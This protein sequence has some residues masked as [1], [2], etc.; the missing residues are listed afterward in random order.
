MLSAQANILALLAQVEDPALTAQSWFA[1]Q[2]V[3]G[4]SIVLIALVLIFLVIL[5]SRSWKTTFGIQQAHYL[6]LGLL[7]AIIAMT[8]FAL[9]MV[10]LDAGNREH[11][12]TIVGIVA[13][14]GIALASTP[15]LSNAMAGL[16]LITGGSFRPGDYI[17]IGENFGRVTKRRL[18][19]LTMQTIDRDLL[20][21]PNLYVVSNPHK[22]IR[23]SG[24]IISCVVSLGYD[25]NYREVELAMIRAALEAQ[26]DNPF[27]EVQ[28][29]GDYSVVYRVAGLLTNVRYL[30]SERSNLRKLVMQS[31]HRDGIEIVSP[32]FMNQRQIST[33]KVMS[34]SQGSNESASPGA[35]PE[36]TMFDEAEEV[37]KIQKLN[38]KLK[39]FRSD[40]EELKNQTLNDGDDP[41]RHQL[42]IV[43]KARDIK[44]IERIIQNKQVEA[45]S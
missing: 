25:V 15:F 41:N 39:T 23:E 2:I 4:A 31:L 18:F 6:R 29:L 36:D 35:R 7:V 5:R 27:V 37:A 44:V 8:I 28:T 24:T 11:M 40:L 42:L 13:S 9:L 12:L 16:M 21:L 22:V 3:L 19:H 20:T 34:D 17:E 26:L 45:E 38:D 30:I 32:S 10:F 33:E 14:I 43:R 1:P